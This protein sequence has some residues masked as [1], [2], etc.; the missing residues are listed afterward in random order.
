MSTLSYLEEAWEQS[1][2]R[3]KETQNYRILAPVTLSEVQ[4]VSFSSN[5]YLGLRRD[6]RLCEAALSAAR[7]Y[8]VGSGVSRSVGQTNPS[9]VTLECYFAEKAGF[10]RSLFF[11]SGFI[12]NL[13]FF[14][15]MMPMAVEKL[16]QEFFVD[17]RCH[18][19]LFYSL[20]QKDLCHS[21]FRHNDA[22]HLEMKLKHSSAQAKIIVTESLFSMDGDFS[23]AE[24]LVCL[25]EKYGALLFLDESHSFGLYGEHG[26]GWNTKYPHLKKFLIGASFG[27]GK[28]IG[29]SGGFLGI[30][31]P[32]FYERMVQKS[33]FLIYSTAVSPLITGAVQCSLELIH[34]KEGEE[35]RNKLFANIVYL[36]KQLRDRNFH[37]PFILEPSHHSPIFPFIVGENQKALYLESYFK[38]YGVTLRAIRPPT[39]PNKTARLRLCLNSEHSF[40][41]IDLFLNLLQEGLK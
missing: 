29:V 13:A 1:H 10:F 30:N 33:R 27:C 7:S 41:N 4:D 40:E 38:K 8:G 23:V 31:S 28:A 11:P 15:A 18:A 20:K 22:S 17:H 25:C 5:D 19:S 32:L 24:D 37:F 3:L 26:V 39:V 35:R 6:P 9:Q 2:G 21:L 14:D 34:G 12:A 16:D 36:K